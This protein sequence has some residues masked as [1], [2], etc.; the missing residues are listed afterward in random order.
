MACQ[1]FLMIELAAG[2]R[3]RLAAALDAAPVSSVL[4]LPSPGKS[5]AID[6]T[7]ALVELAQKRNVA[8]LLLDD[9]RTARTL[10]ADGVHLSFSADI[11]TVYAAARDQLGG[12]ALIGVS[13]GT[14][15]HDAMTLAEA[16]AD[17]VAFEPVGDGGADD[18]EPSRQLDLVSW[19]AEIF[20]VPSVAFGAE[21]A[22]EARILAEAGADFVA[23]RLSARHSLAD[24]AEQARAFHAAITD[25]A[26]AADAAPRGGS[27]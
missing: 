7:R 19:W 27:A 12:R 26:H 15:R 1:L 20:E 23:L 9:P 10:R 22:A 8:A 3:E 14:S 17:Y 6:Q 5:L 21:T 18:E 25:A 16:G 11:E 4:V 13:P 2:A 24:A